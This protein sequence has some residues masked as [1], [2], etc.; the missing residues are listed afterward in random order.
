MRGSEGGRRINDA[1]SE[2]QRTSP[3]ATTEITR[4]SPATGMFTGEGP[5]TFPD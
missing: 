3:G 5:V 1:M 4:E 2:A